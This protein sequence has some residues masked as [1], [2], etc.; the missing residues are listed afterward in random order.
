MRKDVVYN[1]L[2]E[3]DTSGRMIANGL[4]AETLDPSSPMVKLLN[5]LKYMSDSDK[6]EIIMELNKKMNLE[7]EKRRNI[8]IGASRS[9]RSLERAVAEGA[10]ERWNSVDVSRRSLECFLLY[11]SSHLDDRVNNLQNYLYI[12]CIRNITTVMLYNQLLN[13]VLFFHPL[14][15]YEKYFPLLVI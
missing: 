12:P 11:N 4:I 8:L 7:H 3:G 5:T 10:G 6:E 15:T 2:L 14:L 9:R 1:V 13:F